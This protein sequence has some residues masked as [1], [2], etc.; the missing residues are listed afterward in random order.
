MTYPPADDRLRHLLAQEINCS[1]DTWKL[2]WSIAGDIVKGPAI[3]AEL[4]RIARAHNHGQPCGDRHCPHCFD[5][6]LTE[7][8]S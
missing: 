5:A 1:V 8:G 4:D 2:A 3:R 7:A 6:A